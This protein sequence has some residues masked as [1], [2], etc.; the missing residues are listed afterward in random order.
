MKTGNTIACR[1]A[2]YGRYEDR[3]WSHL[4]EI[5]IRHVEIPAPAPR[6]QDA[7]RRRLSDHGLTATSVQARC[8]ITQLK[9]VD[10]M[11]PQLESCA[12]LGARICFVSIKAGGQPRSLVWKRLRAIGDAAGALNV[13]VAM[14]T[15]PDL[16]TNGDVAC[17]T[18]RAIGHPRIRVNF[19]TANIYFYNEK[20]TAVAELKKVIDY[21]AAVHIKDTPGGYQTWDFPTLGTGVVD[22]PSIFQRLNQQGF[23]G[24]FTIELEG[25]KGQERD[26]A[27]QLQY[28]ADSVAYLR[29]IGAFGQG[30]G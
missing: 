27:G 30:A 20:R 6:E 29:H 5:G 25:T 2:S 21:V 18:M 15:H 24:P 14:E 22:F 1:I 12:A 13:T 7:I 26:E 9:A 3:A 8:D 28:V 4:P 11:Q 10:V 17:Q 16:I 19:D 23:A